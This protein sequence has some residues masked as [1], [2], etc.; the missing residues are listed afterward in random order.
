MDRQKLLNYARNFG[1]EARAN[2]RNSFMTK[3][4]RE[5]LVST[6][7]VSK[8]SDIPEDLR[9]ELQAE[10]DAGYQSESKNYI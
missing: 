6:A 9:Q 3:D 5:D 10:F 1:A 4:D 8:W 2:Y 7:G